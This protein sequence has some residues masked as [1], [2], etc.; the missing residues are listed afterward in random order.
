MKI[1]YTFPSIH[2]SK[3]TA[4]FEEDYDVRRIIE[5][6]E[7]LEHTKITK[8][9]TLIIFD[10]VQNAPVVVESLKYFCE[11]TPEYAV[12]AAGELLRSVRQ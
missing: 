9:K 12:V 11:D 8:Q 2:N 3:V 6:L 4:I 7:I 5:T 1:L 10:E